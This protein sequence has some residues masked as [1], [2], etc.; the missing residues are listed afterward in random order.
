MKKGT[1]I[2]RT[3]CDVVFIEQTQQV[4]KSTEI[5]LYFGLFQKQPK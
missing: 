1:A 2:N 3:F 5:L 4:H